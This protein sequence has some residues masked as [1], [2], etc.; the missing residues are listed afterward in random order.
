MEKIPGD[1]PKPW[2][3]A[4]NRPFLDP[5]K[6]FPN[7]L[8]LSVEEINLGYEAIAQVQKQLRQAA[9]TSLVVPIESLRELSIDTAERDAEGFASEGVDAR[10]LGRNTPTTIAG[11]DIRVFDVRVRETAV[12][13]IAHEVPRTRPRL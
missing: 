3:D 11:G 4:N 7:E 9:E 10:A 8:G 12:V 2:R 6:P 5:S 1:A 13:E